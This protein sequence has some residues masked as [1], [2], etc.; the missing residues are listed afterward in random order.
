M[1][2]SERSDKL[3]LMDFLRFLANGNHMLL[4]SMTSIGDGIVDCD[5]FAA[6]H[7]LGPHHCREESVTATDYWRAYEKCPANS[8]GLGIIEPRT[9]TVRSPERRGAESVINPSESFLSMST[10]FGHT[11]NYHHRDD[12]FDNNR[13]NHGSTFFRLTFHC[14]A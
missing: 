6:I 13:T 7:K 4:E 8:A 14:R 1:G 10:S 3:E 9:L 12:N 2:E 11:E 5:D